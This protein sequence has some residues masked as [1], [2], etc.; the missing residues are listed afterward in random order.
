MP[1]RFAGDCAPH[2]GYQF[3]VE[4]LTLGPFSVDDL[5]QHETY[6]EAT[7]PPMNFQG[8]WESVDDVSGLSNVVALPVVVTVPEPGL[9][10]GLIAGALMLR[11]LRARS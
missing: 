11:C 8:W 10:A 2:V 4:S 9:V 5:T 7:T 3:R 6:C 1:I